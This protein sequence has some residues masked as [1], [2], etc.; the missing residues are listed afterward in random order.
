MTNNKDAIREAFGKGS[1]E[2][3]ALALVIHER[4]YASGQP[5]APPNPHPAPAY[6]AIAGL[7]L[8][9]EALREAVREHL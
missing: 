9:D 8:R 4:L 5:V 6:R 3:E 2:Q 1:P 7:I